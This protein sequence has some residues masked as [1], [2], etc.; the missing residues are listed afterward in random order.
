MNLDEIVQDFDGNPD[1]Q[2]TLSSPN[3]GGM[4]STVGMLARIL[5][6]SGYHTST[7]GIFPS[8]ITDVREA[9]DNYFDIRGNRSKFKGAR[10][11]SQLVVAL[12][13]KPIPDLIDK[14]TE[15]GVFVYD[16]KKIELTEK[17]QQLLDSK[18]ATIYKLDLSEIEKLTPEERKA[19]LNTKHKR[20]SI[21]LGFILSQLGN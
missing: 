1:V 11:K 10:E 12:Y 16:S 13:Q 7:Q 2:V 15:G 4:Q 19:N 14:L 5:F 17:Q 9:Y 8:N 3:G 18:N 6:Q 20:H 21:V